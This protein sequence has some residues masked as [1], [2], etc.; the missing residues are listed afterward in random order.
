MV[1]LS[2]LVR[3]FKRLR[4]NTARVSVPM[5]IAVP[6]AVPIAA[7]I[8]A[9]PATPVAVPDV[10]A[11]A[12]GTIW[13]RSHQSDRRAV[14]LADR[15][16]S[17]RTPGSKQCMP[18]GRQFVLVTEDGKALWAVSWPLAKFTRHAWAGAWVCT[19]FRNEGAGRSSALIKE[20]IALTRYRWPD[21]PALGL[22]TFVNPRRIEN[23][24]RPG[25]CFTSAGF[26]HVGYTEANKLLVFQ[27]L[28]ENMPEPMSF[29]KDRPVTEAVRAAARARI[30]ARAARKSCV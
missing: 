28:P 5:P 9:P 11:P 10:T 29:F 16:Y 4:W 17:R 20:A 24:S 15:H 8:P 2:A 13:R 14:R 12:Y 1:W 27:M 21:I 7:P 6:V 23:G 25:Y 22:I 3:Y 26:S 30:A 19:L 18:P